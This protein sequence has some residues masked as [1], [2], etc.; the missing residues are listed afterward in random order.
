MEKN[1]IK[2]HKEMSKIIIFLLFWK[3]YVKLTA[4]VKLKP[5]SWNL[6]PVYSQLSFYSGLTFEYNDF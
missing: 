5:I 3:L 4:G 2:L 1:S 6:S